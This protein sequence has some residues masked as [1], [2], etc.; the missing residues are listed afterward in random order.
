MFKYTRS[1][2]PTR[3]LPSDWDKKDYAAA[4]KRI[5]DAEFTRWEPSVAPYDPKTN[6][7]PSVSSIFP[8]R[9]LLSIRVLLPFAIRSLFH[10]ALSL[11]NLH[12]FLRLSWS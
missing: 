6:P 3:S 7:A 2:D 8:N 5:T 9:S 12:I 11:T 4:L 1:E 10:S